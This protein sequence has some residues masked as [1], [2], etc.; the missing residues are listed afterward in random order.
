MRVEYPRAICHVVA[1]GGRRED[2]FVDEVDRQDF[3]QQMIEL[4]AGELGENETAPC[5]QLQF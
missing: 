1:R 2:I 3:K 4:M 5:I